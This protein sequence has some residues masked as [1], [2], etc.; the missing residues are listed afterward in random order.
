MKQGLNNSK[1]KNINFN[2]I[3]SNYKNF[4]SIDKNSLVY[5]YDDQRKF[6]TLGYSVK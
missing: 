2:K 5:I 3:K 6:N 1:N 4:L